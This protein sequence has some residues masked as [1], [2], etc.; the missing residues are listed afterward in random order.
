MKFP[1]YCNIIYLIII[2]IFQTFQQSQKC[3]S[4]QLESNKYR[5]SDSSYNIIVVSTMLMNVYC[6]V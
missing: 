1:Y 2:I 5:P 4:Q 6:Y 3:R